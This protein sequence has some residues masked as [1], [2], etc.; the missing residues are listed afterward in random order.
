[1]LQFPKNIVF[2]SLTIIFVLANSE[3]PD[4]M[5]HFAAFHLGLQY[6]SKYLFRGFLSTK[7][8]YT[9]FNESTLFLI[10][11][12][13]YREKRVSPPPTLVSERKNIFDYDEF[14]VFHR[15]DV[16]QDQIRKGKR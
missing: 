14:D 12:F 9:V 11:S 16:K 4:E 3:D 8:S 10:L 13:I 5:P 6:L 2:L 1:M 7:G 15:D